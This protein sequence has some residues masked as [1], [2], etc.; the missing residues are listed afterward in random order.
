MRLRRE[1]F[2]YKVFGKDI[3]LSKDVGISHLSL[4]NKVYATGEL[5]EPII[6]NNL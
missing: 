5:S 2:S 4:D 6:A 3:P 1:S